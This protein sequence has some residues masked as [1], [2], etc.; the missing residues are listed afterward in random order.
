MPT[1]DFAFT[2][3]ASLNAVSALHHNPSVLR[4]LTPPPLIATF[5]HIEP[6]AEGSQ[7]RFTLWLGPIPIRWQA[8]HHKVSLQGFADEQI[9]GPLQA[10]QHTHTFQPL[11]ETHTTI[12]EHIEYQHKPGWR[13]WLTRLLFS[14]P[15]LHFLFRYRAWVTRRLLARQSTENRLKS[16]T[17]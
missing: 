16:P 12:H 10:W 3:P 15:G 6:L 5:Q 2:V 7:V 1:F 11:D 4:A 14:P 8:R 17:L 9:N 13:G